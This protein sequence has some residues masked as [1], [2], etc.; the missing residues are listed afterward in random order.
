MSR[1]ISVGAMLGAAL[2]SAGCG[3]G[4]DQSR[5]ESADTADFCSAYSTV[6]A[7]ASAKMMPLRWV[8]RMAAVGVP[9]DAPPD[10]HRGLDDMVSLYREATR[11]EIRPGHDQGDQD[12]F[13]VY[14]RRTC[15]APGLSLGGG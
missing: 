11:G 10:A 6:P 8:Q 9:A 13:V 4:S 15:G 3:A 5:T 14:A 1:F 12:A 2:L 7:A